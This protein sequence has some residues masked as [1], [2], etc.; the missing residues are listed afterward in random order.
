[1]SC[2]TTAAL[3]CTIVAGC[4]TSQ[5]GLTPRKPSHE[6]RL[7]VYAAGKLIGYCHGYFS[8]SG[9]SVSFHTE[10]R[11]GSREGSF[12]GG[13]ISDG[14]YD[15]LY[16]VPGS[17]GLNGARLLRLVR[18]QSG[19]TKRGRIVGV[20]TAGAKLVGFCVPGAA[21]GSLVC[22]GQGRQISIYDLRARLLGRCTPNDLVSG[23]GNLACTEEVPGNGPGS[24][25][26]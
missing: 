5:P 7:P 15:V 19:S 18:V 8:G 2:A 16:K 22:T 6:R 13:G 25:S 12:C 4:G 14:A 3:A 1:M 21:T 10:W 20:Y 11:R 24:V 17:H 23:Q 9:P 26:A